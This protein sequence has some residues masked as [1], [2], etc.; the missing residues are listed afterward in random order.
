MNKVIHKAKSSI[1]N[2]KK[3]YLFLSVILLIGLISGIIFI[4]FISSEDK[5]LVKEE[6]E[7]F[8]TNISTNKL[9]YTETFINSIVSNLLYVFVIWVLGVSIIGIPIIIFILFLKGFILGFSCSS[10]IYNFGFKGMGLAMGQI[11]HNLF[12]LLF[13][14]LIGFYAINFSIRLFRVL[15]LKETIA[16]NSYFKRY[17]KVLGIAVLGS[18]FC[19][20]LEVFLAPIIINLFL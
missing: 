5:L 7:L 8:F 18:V 11:P 10:I 17:N 4:F 12:L 20:L 9:N 6:L 19:S 15:F 16:L 2:Q 14:V 3:K 1:M 13:L